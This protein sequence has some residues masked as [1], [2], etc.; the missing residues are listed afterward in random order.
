MI[1]FMWERFTL[2]SFW[3]RKK[4]KLFFETWFHA[5]WDGLKLFTEVRMTSDFWSSCLYFLSAEPEVC[6]STWCFSE[7]NQGLYISS[8]R[9]N[10]LSCI[11]T[12]YFDDDTIQVVHLLENILK[13]NKR[14][15]WD[16]T[17]WK[18]D[19]ESQSLK[20]SFISLIK[21]IYLLKIIYLV[22]CIVQW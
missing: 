7:L 3:E 8:G 17:D 15:R 16:V 20:L 22:N 18:T 4:F 5:L 11:P 21:T 13:Q 10:K 19:T 1:V 12:W 14:H 6:V 2:N 9:L